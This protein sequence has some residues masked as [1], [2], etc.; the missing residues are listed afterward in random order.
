MPILKVI[1]AQNEQRL[2]ETGIRKYQDDNTLDMLIRYCTNRRKTPR[3]LIGSH[4]IM[5]NPI[6]EMQQIAER[7]R[8]NKGLRARHWIISFDRWEFNRLGYDPYRKLLELAYEIADFYRSDYQILFAVHEDCPEHPHV[9]FVMNTVN[10]RTGRKYGGKK[11][12]YYDFQKHINQILR[13]YKLW[14]R[15]VPDEGKGTYWS[16]PDLEGSHFVLDD[17]HEMPVNAQE[18]AAQMKFDW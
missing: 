18:A 2:H 14:I 1:Y 17:A 9:H 11:K 12:D 16:M 8:K 3:G 6:L 4:N 5:N 10:F 7:F 13:P 15:T